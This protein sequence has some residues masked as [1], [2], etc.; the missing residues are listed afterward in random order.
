[1]PERVALITGGSR[2]IGRALGL[3]LAEAGWDIALCHRKSPVEAESAAAAIAALGRRVIS[4]QCDVSDPEAAAACVREVEE[5][6]GRID[7]LLNCAGA[8]HRVPL[9]QETPAGWQEMFAHNLHPVFYL[10][11]LVA[12][13][14]QRRRWGRI[15][16]FSIVHADQLASQPNLTAHYIAKVGV[17][18]LTR[19]FATLLAPDGITVNAISPAFIDSGTALPAG[20][21]NTIQKIPAGHAGTVADAV[22]VVKFLLSPEAGYVTGTNIHLSGGWGI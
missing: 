20:L 3:A 9:L 4:R 2:G 16:N 1:M 13:G 12:P 5:S 11:R 10:S 8:F 17:L 18:I 19:T 7:A 21:Q 6:W 14:M 15:V 22:A